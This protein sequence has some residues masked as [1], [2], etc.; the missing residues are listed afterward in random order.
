MA[1]VFSF[2]EPPLIENDTLLHLIHVRD[3][4]YQFSIILEPVRM[5]PSKAPNGSVFR[6]SNDHRTEL[7]VAVAVM[8]VINAHRS[9]ST[10]LI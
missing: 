7:F 9:W 4:A 10:I 8:D 2:G 6:A 5:S 1:A 3:H